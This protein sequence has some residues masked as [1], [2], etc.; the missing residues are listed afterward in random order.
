MTI[1]ELFFFLALP[2]S[3]AFCFVFPLPDAF[4]LAAA[5]GGASAVLSA[6]SLFGFAVLLRLLRGRWSDGP[7]F[8][9][10]GLVATVLATVGAAYFSWHSRFSLFGIVGFAAAS[11]AVYGTGRWSIV[12]W[13]SL[14]ASVIIAIALHVILRTSSIA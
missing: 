13:S 12:G 10:W 9:P 5:I 6:V 14:V 11:V 3:V 2:T 1:I 8:T 7:A 4:R